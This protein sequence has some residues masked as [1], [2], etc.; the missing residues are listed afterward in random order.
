MNTNPQSNTPS[1]S[2]GGQKT[3]PTSGVQALAQER[4]TESNALQIPQISL[5]KGGG[6]LKG[7]DEKFQVNS[8][9]GTASFSIPLPFSPNRN[10]FTPSLA[11]SYN[12]GSG[13]SILG[14]GWALDIPSIVR[15]TDKILPRYRDFT[16][17]EDVFMFSGAEDL[18]PM[19]EW[20][21]DHW[22]KLVREIKGYRIESYRPRIEGAFSK[23]ERISH[24]MVGVYWRVV[25]RDNIT[26]I[27]GRNQSHRLCDPENPERVYQWLPEFSFDDKGSAVSFEF[28][29]E[30]LANVAPAS[31]EKNRLA[32]V[33]QFANRYL[34]RVCYGNV[35]PYYSPQDCPFDPPM[36]KQMDQWH[37]ELVM[38]YGEHDSDTPTP[39]ETGLWAARPD[40]FSSHRS[41]FDMR[42][43]RLLRRA[44]MFHRFPE[45]NND[46]STLVRSLD[47]KYV[48]SDSAQSD[49]ETELEFLKSITQA[50]YAW[51]ADENRYSRKSLPPMEF[52][53][54]TLHWDHQIRDVKQAD[55]IHSPVGLSS[56]YQWTDLYNEG[57]PGILSEQGT[58]WFY[59]HNLGDVDEDGDVRF[60]RAQLVMDKPS[61]TG[62]GNGT[63][64]LQ[65]LEANGQK[66]IVI[67]APGV[68]GYFQLSESEEG[69]WEPFK[70]FLNRVNI[71][72]RD[73]NVRV[74]DVNGD[75]QSDIVLTDQGAFWW[76]PGKGKEGYG[77][78]E[79][80]PQPFDEELGP[81]IV[82]SDKEQRIFLADM[83][84]D[85]LTDLV[86][87]RN[88]E[89]CYWPNMG[90]GRFGAKV[91]MGN[92]PW[93]DEPDLFNPDYLQ[94]ADISGTGASD[95]IYLGKSQ[96]KAWL[97]LSGNRWG[98]TEEIAPIFP[99]E[100]PNRISVTD[101]LGNGVSCIVWSSELPANAERPMRYIDLM[102]GVKPH[103]MTHY[104]NNMGK[105]VTLE[106]KSSTWYYLKDKLAGKPWITRLAFPVQCVRKTII[107]EKIS[108]L[109][110]ASEYSY[111]HGYY[112]HTEREFRGFG[113][114][115]QLDTETFGE[116][117]KT[118]A[119]N[120]RSESLHQPPVL[121]KTWF[122]TGLFLDNRERVLTHFEKEYWYH[123]PD[124][125]AS[126]IHPLEIA[127]PDAPVMTAESVPP[128]ASVMEKLSPEEW[129]EALRA[130]KGMPL[131]QEVF[132]PEPDP[133][134]EQNPLVPYNA[135]TH[136]CEIQIL[137]PREGNKY[138]VFIVKESEAI[139]WHYERRSEDPRVAHTLNIEVD[140]Y[141]NVLESASVVYGR[142]K[143]P[144][145]PE[146]GSAETQSTSLQH[147]LEKAI[148]AQRQ[149]HIV[150]TRN[151]FTVDNQRGDHSYRLPVLWQT[152][153]YELNG[154]L[155]AR[156]EEHCDPSISLF[157]IADFKG[158]LLDNTVVERPYHE[159]ETPQ[160]QRSKR[161]IERVRTLFLN[162]ADLSSALPLGEQGQRGLPYE[163]YQLAYTPVLLNHLFQS[164]PETDNTAP[165]SVSDADMLEGRFV[166]LEDAWWI[167]SGITHFIFGAD[168]AAEAF[169]RFFVPVAYTDPF[170]SVT[171]VEYDPHTLFI[172][173]AV[174]PVGNVSAVDVFNY[175]TL[176][177]SRMRDPNDDLSEVLL[178]ELGLVKAMA[179]MGKGNEADDLLGL[180]E[181]ETPEESALKTQFW[182]ETAQTETDSFALQTQA[183]E[184]LAH[185]SARFIYDFDRYLLSGQPVAVAGIS[186]EEHHAV[187]EQR[188]Q[189]DQH[190]VQI[191]IE[192]S[193]GLGKV[194]MKKAQ[195]EPGDAKKLVTQPGGEHSVEIVDT[196]MRMRWVGNGRTV[197]NNKGNPVLQ[198]EP[199]FST[200]AGYESAPI[201]VENGVFV[202]ISYDAL[203]RT[204]RTDFPDG[205]HSRVDF[206]A[207]QQS[208]YDQNDTA[209]ETAWYQARRHA[210]GDDPVAKGLRRAAKSVELHHNTPSRLF[211]DSLG[212][213]VLAVEH[214]KDQQDANERHYTRVELDIEGNARAV[215][216]A[217]FNRV[218]AYGYDMLGHRVFQDSMDAGKRWMLNNS[219]GNPVRMWDQRKHLFSFRFDALHRPTES[220]VQGG[221]A[222][223]PLDAV[224]EK[225]VYGENQSDDKARRLRGKVLYQ[226]DTAGRNTVEAYDFKG[227][228]LRAARRL[229]LDYQQTPDWSISDPETLLQEE[230]FVSSSLFDALNRPVQQSAPRSDAAPSRKYNIVQTQYNDAGLLERTYA[231]LQRDDAAD[232]LLDTATATFQPVRNVDYNEKAQRTRIQYGNGVGTRYEYDPETFRLTRMRSTRNGHPP[233]GGTGGGYLQDLQYTYDPVGN[234]TQVWDQAIPTVF[235]AN[236][237]VE[238]ISKY[239]YDSLYRLTEASGRE[240]IG[241]NDAGDF[242]NWSDAWAQVQL[243]PNDAV[244]LREYT[245][246]YQYDPVGNILQMRHATPNG[247]GNWTRNNTYE[248]YNNRLKTTETGG[249][250]HTYP[251]HAQHGFMTAMPH[252]QT[253][254]WNFREELAQ[255]VRTFSADPDATFYTYDAGG[256]RSRK[257]NVSAGG[258]L[259]NERLYLGGFEI[260]RNAEGLERETLHLMDGEKRILMVDMRTAGTDDYEPVLQRYQLGNHLGSVALELDEQ[261]E[262]I[263]Y[264]E[265][266]PYG[267]TAYQAVSATICATVKRYRYTGMERDEETGLEYHTAR[268][269][270][271]W[272]GRWLSADPIGIKD[273]YNR[274]VYTKNNPISATDPSGLWTWGDVAIIAAVVVVS[275]AVTVA[276]AGAAGPLIAGAV[277]SA[278]LTGTA[279]AVTTGV[280]VGAVAGAAGGASAELTRQVASGEQINGRAIGI[281]AL[282]GA[283][284]GA[285]TGGIGSAATAIRAT[286]TAAAS[287]GLT[288]SVVGSTSRVTSIARS[289][290]GGAATGATGGAVSE[291]TRQVASGE[292]INGAN[293]LR[294]AGTG[295]IVGGG[296]KIA[297]AGSSVVRQSLQNRG[298]QQTGV[299]SV[300]AVSQVRSESQ[301]IAAIEKNADDA[302]TLTRADVAAGRLSSGP[303]AFGTRAHSHFERL[304]IQLNN[305]LIAE[306][307]TFRIAA[308]EFRDAAGNLAA[309]RASGSIGADVILRNP[310]VNSTRV[311]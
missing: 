212:R 257:I 189:A 6:A 305:Q 279:A 245:Q 75:G 280:V 62:L 93:F 53:Y 157:K 85:G 196:N 130:C 166:P 137:Q 247:A 177:P 164:D 39:E 311:F 178:D 29:A 33:S 22:K 25:T 200:S 120:A 170:G 270:V 258:V 21:C 32:G 228:P 198:Y 300:Q 86:R 95:L 112:D 218:M 242:D 90:Y 136:N 172:Q 15:R 113:R 126:G 155:P 202:Q 194:A 116:L 308:E 80:V 60:E 143:D 165:V 267:T 98:S 288:T 36:W 197:L 52:E 124:L 173:Q 265:Y 31:F 42:T 213:P 54:Q 171:S 44:L 299:R 61:L 176:A 156:P 73:P 174:D 236:H 104:R 30:D 244:A 81:A 38:D 87:I 208:T 109:R 142:L 70:S 47:F 56:N 122:H 217:R 115:E 187:L 102:G 264:E 179:I 51:I 246:T 201:L 286:G 306:G 76:W 11:A 181:W 206:D 118:G 147:C 129:R 27:F 167:R 151:E 2:T 287:T 133:S 145:E 219:L 89:V 64:Q 149:M 220:R 37:F 301:I 292:R 55:L 125:S 131:R 159:I 154:L 240:H 88:G 259:K 231:W 138:A 275:V 180:Q 7:I 59:K 5:P 110:F 92:A 139:T 69:E 266:H 117:S 223:E 26:T 251:H 43:Y 284:G 268:Y 235:F 207:W 68:Q 250:T 272:L 34:K 152:S 253:M 10:G 77:D 222:T 82:F 294:A 293:V 269:Y 241:Q 8:S 205:T 146:L 119:S 99:T 282:S 66:Q 114:V 72:L 160:D 105:E 3:H 140:E 67:N 1:Q 233:T 20:D 128:Q 50:G 256:Q 135:A 106:Y 273:H 227:N 210:S 150:Y 4:A 188:G 190:R 296:V 161:L 78:P 144:E 183:R 83:C 229:T 283:A 163:N 281:S 79:K 297:S 214:L 13:N 204:V 302:V 65:D 123:H 278:G 252:L 303:Q 310:S 226:Y 101:L 221:D 185:T 216:D 203:G 107:E 45:L 17:E 158:I 12:S 58:G 63:L 108:G 96:F 254:Q 141:G 291:L 132:S 261:S 271:V 234:I 260:Y 215:Y 175:R 41:G 127:L 169:S 289:V 153:A 94:L 162:D 274:Y 276:T 168:T 46:T 24:S 121:T 277:A 184:L 97:N 237:R 148:Q 16:E 249:K 309:T 186:R 14:I 182:N 103:I 195:A 74:F 225:I 191:A 48:V 295:A 290:A 40:P 18:V 71:D 84:G 35:K 23:I 262:V 243:S 199:Y 298:A 134:G 91:T 209:R 19:L 57:I 232:T 238:P 49:R 9:N 304:N 192:Y 307:N 111:H 239:Q 230:S 28:K 193:D 255:T 211:L 248:A 224:Y 285:L 100:K 263:S